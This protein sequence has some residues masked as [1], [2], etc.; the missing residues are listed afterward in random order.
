MCLCACI[1]E[2]GSSI[3]EP[4]FRHRGFRAL[5]GPLDSPINLSFKIV[6]ACVYVYM[7]VCVYISIYINMNI[8]MP[9]HVCGSERKTHGNQFLDC[10]GPRDWIWVS[11]YLLS[12][13][14]PLK[15]F[16]RLQFY[17]L[18]VLRQRQVNQCSRLASDS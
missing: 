18:D 1:W 15:P 16:E 17:R 11:L 2:E 10:V 3:W 9:W 7:Y 14:V 8:H 12:H 4:A 5:I 13:S 6:C